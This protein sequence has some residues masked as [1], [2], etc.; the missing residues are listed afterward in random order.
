MFNNF[1]ESGVVCDILWEK[2][3][4]QTGDRL[5]YNITRV[6]CILDNHK[7]TDTQSENVKLIAFHSN[8]G[9]VKAFQC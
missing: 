8:N 3:Y 4:N 5:Q 1:S 2:W 9:F 7:A 6:L